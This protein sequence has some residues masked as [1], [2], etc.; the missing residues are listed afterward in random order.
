LEGDRRLDRP[1]GAARARHRVSLRDARSRRRS[2]SGQLRQKSRACA[3]ARPPRSDSRP[4]GS[5]SDLRVGTPHTRVVIRIT[6]GMREGEIL[7]LRWR[8]V[9]TKARLIQV[10]RQYTHG[11]LV[12]HAK[13]CRP[14]RHRD[15][16]GARR[17]AHDLEARAEA[18]STPRRLPRDRH[19]EGGP[20]GA[21]NFLS[22]EFRPALVKAELPRV[23]F[24]SQQ[25]SQT[26]PPSP[27]AA[28]AYQGSP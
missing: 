8:D 18:R 27:Q 21:S 7:G 16:P 12:E 22:R 11:E 17:R 25:A 6:A 1:Q 13:R 28:A 19:Q 4:N 15:R 20:I 3:R 2:E 10:R 5:P 26:A 23:D 24:H 9:D 14:A